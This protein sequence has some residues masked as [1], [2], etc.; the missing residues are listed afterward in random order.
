MKDGLI[1]QSLVCDYPGASARVHLTDDGELVWPVVFMY[2]QYQIN[3]FIPNFNE[4]SWYILQI[5]YFYI[6]KIL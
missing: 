5:W 1:P 6:F 3:D 2:P 4:N